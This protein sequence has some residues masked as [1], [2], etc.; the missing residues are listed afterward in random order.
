MTEIDDAYWR[1]FF[2]PRNY[3][4]RMLRA[5][6]MG[7]RRAKSASAIARA[8]KFW[9][10]PPAHYWT[11]CDCNAKAYCYDHRDYRKPMDVWPVCKR[12]DCI[13]GAAKPYDGIDPHWNA[14]RKAT[15]KRIAAMIAAEKAYKKAMQ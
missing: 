4:A 5:K 2:S 9:I 14:R 8:I 6:N 13:R 3:S 15:K 7:K 12:C 10:L 11:C 1:E